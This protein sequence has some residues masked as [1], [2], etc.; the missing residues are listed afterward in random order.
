MTLNIEVKAPGLGCNVGSGFNKDGLAPC[1]HCFQTLGH[2]PPYQHLCDSLTQFIHSLYR[3]IRNKIIAYVILG[4]Q[5][6]LFSKVRSK[7]CKS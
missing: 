3:F 7:T 4:A 1:D 6:N 5:A 2:G